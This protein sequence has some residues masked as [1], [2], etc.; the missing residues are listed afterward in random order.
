MPDCCRWPAEQ[1]R[2]PI[3]CPLLC[4]T[5]APV[6]I[7]TPDPLAY[8]QTLPDLCHLPLQDFHLS[9]QALHPLG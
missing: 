6:E 5:D 3:K 9:L 8:L 2:A 1:K 7:R 4:V